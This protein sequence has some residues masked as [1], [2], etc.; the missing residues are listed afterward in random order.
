[1]I[2]HRNTRAAAVKLGASTSC[3]IW[4]GVF[5]PWQIWNEFL[6]QKLDLPVWH[7][8]SQSDIVPGEADCGS[9][10]SQISLRTTIV[11]GQSLVGSSLL[12]ELWAPSIQ[13]ITKQE[14]TSGCF[15]P[16]SDLVLHTQSRVYLHFCSFLWSKWQ[17]YLLVQ[18]IEPGE[19]KANF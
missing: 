9:P 18:L 6:L 19:G 16:T 4:G 1:M 11:V 5:I 8:A 14:S 17:H 7:R 13:R 10:G 3:L 15:V 2:T 12:E